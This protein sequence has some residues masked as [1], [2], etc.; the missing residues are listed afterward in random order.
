MIHASYV[1]LLQENNSKF[2]YL[3]MCIVMLIC[4]PVYGTYTNVI[5]SP[6]NGTGMNMAPGI[7][8]TKNKKLN[9]EQNQSNINF[10]PVNIFVKSKRF[11]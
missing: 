3:T 8:E 4:E 5:K 10:K 11:I 2:S 1:V 9:L 7:N 6:S